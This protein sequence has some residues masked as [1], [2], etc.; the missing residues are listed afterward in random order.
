MSLHLA[1][2]LGLVAAEGPSTGTLHSREPITALDAA[3]SNAAKDAAPWMVLL[4]NVVG[5]GERCEV[6]A[7]LTHELER[8]LVST[9]LNT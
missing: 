2:R 9:N 5:G 8:R 3:A 1:K 4:H 6:R 7:R